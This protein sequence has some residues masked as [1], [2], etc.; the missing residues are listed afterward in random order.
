MFIRVGLAWVACVLQIGAGVRLVRPL[1][2]D[3]KLGGV[4]RLGG[5]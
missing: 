5:E 4:A 2:E 3:P 1:I